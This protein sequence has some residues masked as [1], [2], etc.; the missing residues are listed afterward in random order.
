MMNHDPFY[1]KCLSHLSVYS[2]MRSRRAR[3]EA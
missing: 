2:Y 1:D 3:L